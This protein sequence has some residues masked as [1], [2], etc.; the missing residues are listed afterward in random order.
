VFLNIF[1]LAGRRKWLFRREWPCPFT[2]VQHKQYSRNLHYYRNAYVW[3]YVCS[4]YSKLR[5][6]PDTEIEKFVIIGITFANNNINKL[7]YRKRTH[8]AQLSRYRPG[9]ALGVPGGWGSRISRQSAQ[10]GGKVVSPSHRPSLLQKGFL[11]LISVTGWVDPRVTMRPEG[12]SHWKIP[13][14]PSRIE[15]VTFWF[16]AQCLN[17]PTERKGNK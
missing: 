8:S 1:C 7:S 4:E 11:V 15:P 5:P 16:V 3:A 9:Q 12:L 6:S 10:E 13:V 2:T 17:Q 14:T